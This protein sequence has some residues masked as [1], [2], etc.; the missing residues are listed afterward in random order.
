[1]RRVRLCLIIMSLFATL[2]AVAQTNVKGTVLDS[3]S[4][5]PEVGA[6]VR[7]IKNGE[8]RPAAYSVTDSLGKF[9]RS[10]PGSGE[11]VL[12]LQNMGRKAVSRSFKLDGQE[13]IDLG[14]ILL[15]DD[16]QA[17]NSASVQAMKTLVK[18]D[19]NKLTYKVEA[20]P[21]S[22]TG[23]LLDML[24]KVPMVTV[25]GQDN[26]TVNGS[27]SF[28][29][30]LDGKPN[31]MLSSNPSQILKVMPASAVKDI[32]VI[33]NPGAKYDAEGAGGILNLITGAATGTSSAVADG[34]YG[35]VSAGVTTKG[36]NG[37][38]YLT[39]KKGKLTVGVN[40]AGG[41]QK[42]NGISYDATQKNLCNGDSQITEMIQSQKSPF[43]FADLNASYEISPS[44]L[45]S[46]S[47]GMTGFYQSAG[48]NSTITMG[49]AAPYSYINDQEMKYRTS[50]V[51]GS[52]DFQHTSA[53]VAGRTLTL[54]Y[55]YS[56]EPLRTEF[57]SRFSG[58]PI[59][60]PD[61]KSD[62]DD[63]SQENT[64][65]LDYTT[66]VGKGQSLSSGLK[67]IA[68]HN[69]A[70]DKLYFA[71]GNNWIHNAEGSMLYDHFNN[72]GA[73]YSEY[74]GSFGKFSLI[75]G[76]RY[77][78]TWQKVRYGKGF[79][80]D[81]K[82]GFGDIVPSASLQYNIAATRNIGLTYNRRI[83]R[84]GITYLN[85]YVNRSS[86][87][88]VS[89]GNSDLTS[90]RSDIISVVYNSFTPKWIVSLTVRYSHTGS[91][92]SDYSFYDN[93]G[94]LNTTYGNIVV[95]DETGITAFVNWTA[96]P[97]TRIYTNSSF[98]YSMFSSD[99]LA[100]KDNGWNWN[101]VAGLQ[102]T[103]PADMLLSANLMAGGKTWTLQGW[104]KGF[105]LGVLGLSKG[106][107]ANK[108]R[109]TGQFI[110]NFEKGGMAIESFARGGNFETRSKVTVPIRQ[111]G[112]N[113]T[114][115]FG[116]QGFQVKK[117]RKSITNDDVINNTNGQAPGTGAAG[118]SVTGAAGAGQG[119]M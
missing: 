70:D 16:A 7:F 35:S 19:V 21:D 86:P 46:G 117:T 25:D 77:E 111:V 6:V 69:S 72:I 88:V 5:Q 62:G 38:V 71:D 31:Q 114:Y 14:D 68:R 43:V 39:A 96:G 11:Y 1:M 93:E 67:Y 63:N 61:R 37:G 64:F 53:E 107:F 115:T 74:T 23:S 97:K 45:L 30:Y 78:Y 57:V 40:T 83:Q 84:P 104:N 60:M 108:L 119:G 99:E 47:F 102:Q 56:G 2:T 66:P 49:G 106:F 89:Y 109:V 32:E 3:L 8:D 90:A 33:T 27:S 22:K 54:S 112:L 85:P 92:I 13:D 81:F 105:T 59:Q 80:Q 41:Y 18:L 28:K 42:L 82:T 98:G 103:L 113:L 50:G 48:G 100:Q 51:N 10:I 20:D 65:Q 110:S 52:V 91:G 17:I 26:I 76:L 73:I 12:L 9:E 95:E 55:R 116:K 34:A 36:E 118:S 58:M 15:Q 101:V 79:G 24:R 44:D 75:A 87:T 94:I 29:V 4:R